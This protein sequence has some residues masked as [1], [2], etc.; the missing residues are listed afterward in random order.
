MHFI[1]FF[2]NF[3]FL[4]LVYLS[5]FREGVRKCRHKREREQGE[6]QTERGRERERIPSRLHTVSAASDVGPEP[7]NL[8]IVT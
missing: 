7:T 3:A 2:F 1:L 6:G 8:E 4:S 5:V